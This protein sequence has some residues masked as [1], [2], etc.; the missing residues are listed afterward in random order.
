MSG[1][2]N[3][4]F[5]TLVLCHI[6]YLCRSVVSG[7]RTPNFQDVLVQFFSFLIPGAA[8]LQGNKISELGN[9]VPETPSPRGVLTGQ[10]ETPGMKELV[11]SAQVRLGTEPG[12]ARCAREGLRMVDCRPSA[13]W[14]LEGEI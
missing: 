1:S 12:K 6:S 11:G 3:I 13:S 10:R 2:L 5:D 8:V 7:L 9:W 14:S 4:S